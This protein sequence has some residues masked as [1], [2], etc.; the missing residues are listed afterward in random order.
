MGRVKREAS[1]EPYEDAPR[2]VRGKARQGGDTSTLL[3]QHKI[4]ATRVQATPWPE[5]GPATTAAPCDADDPTVLPTLK[6]YATQS[7]LPQRTQLMDIAWRPPRSEWAAPTTTTPASDVDEPRAAVPLIFHA[8]GASVPLSPQPYTSV[9]LRMYMHLTAADSTS[10]THPCHLL[11][12]G[13][14]IY[15]LAWAPQAEPQDGEYLLVACSQHREPSA[16]VADPSNGDPG[17]LQ[18]WVWDPSTAQVLCQGRWVCDAGAPL[19]VAWRP[20][21]PPPGTLGVAAVSWSDGTVHLLAIP[22][23]SK[24][25]ERLVAERVLRVP[26]T[27]C[28]S[29]AWGGDA[30]LAVGCTNGTIAVW[31]LDVS[32]TPVC[33]APVHDTTVSALSWQMLPPISVDGEPQLEARPHLLFSVGWDGCEHI[34]DVADMEAPLR[35]M[36]SRE[37]RY[38][39]TWLPW[40]GSWAVDLGDHQFGTVSLRTHDMGRHHALGFHH[41]RV[42]CMAASALHPFLATGS[43]EGSVKLTSVLAMAKRK[44]AEEGSRFMHKLFRLA[45]VDDG[46]VWHQGFY[47]EGVLPRAPTRKS[48]PP[49]VIDRWDPQVAVT[50]VAWSPNAGRALLLASGTAL[51][52]VHISWAEG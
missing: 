42:L 39:T 43:A 40:S 19:Q 30:R 36:H 3:R 12:A 13:G 10:A 31:D 28:Y 26:G 18:G 34:T 35:H 11:D 8:A 17:Q 20:A 38:A 27:S 15:D 45:R 32:D 33:V 48:G 1:D 4:L 16:R 49:V 9:P 47:P 5:P 21:P 51:G 23:Q 7:H 6:A 46:F 22:M 14:H 44:T 41:A 29:L 24:G 37:P 25:T 52:L 50:S 2:R